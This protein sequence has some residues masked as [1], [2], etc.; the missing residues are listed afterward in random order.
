MNASAEKTT[1]G[2][3]TIEGNAYANTFFGVEYALPEGFSFYNADQLAEMNASIG[4]T[5]KDQ[6]VVEA[7]KGGTAFF[8]MAAVA[9][10]DPNVS[11]VMEIAGPDPEAAAM[12]EAGYIEAAQNKILDQLADAGATVKSAEA[13]TY[14]N[15]KTGDE[16]T[17]MKLAIEMQGA[18]LC[19][20]VICI[21]AGDC[22][23]NVTATATDEAAL[24]SV[25]SHLTRIG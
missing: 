22:F 2:T 4:D 14:A 23:M 10:S 21:K 9:E 3:G 24:D 8:D 18:P 17:G 25:L 20:E 13:G 12:D 15:Q 5:N 6:E 1:N 11:I 19:E 7:F 16:F